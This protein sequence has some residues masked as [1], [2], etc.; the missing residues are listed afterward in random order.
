[1]IRAVGASWTI[2][3]S[4]IRHIMATMRASYIVFVSIA[5][6]GA[7]HAQPAVEFIP[8]TRAHESAARAY[9]AIWE[10]DGARIV[11]ALEARTCVRFPETAVAAVV[12]DAVSDSGGPEH[13]MSLRA[14]YDLDVKRATLVHELAHRHLWQLAQRLDDVDGHRTLYLILDRV[15]ADVWGP[16]FAA[17]RVRGESSWNATYDY[18]SA[19]TWASK[20][21]VDQR[22]VLWNRLLTMNAKP[23]CY[24]V[25][26]E[27]QTAAARPLSTSLTP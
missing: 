2:E 16:E 21:T 23:Y 7:A 18:A 17:A 27:Q 3:L 4:A 25:Y 5:A 22:G 13:P 10:Q 14:S 9:R 12:G 11:A 1:M 19:W 8:S 6:A 24:A 20:L 15:W 26:V